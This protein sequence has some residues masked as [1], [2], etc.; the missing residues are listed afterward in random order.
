MLTM[1][2]LAGGD[3]NHD[4]LNVMLARVL[5]TLMPPRAQSYQHVKGVTMAV[6][7]RELYADGGI[8]RF[9]RGML[10]ALIMMPLSRFGDIFTNRLAREFQP[11]WLPPAIA[12][13]FA[14]SLAAGWRVLITPADTIKT[15]MQVHGANG[16]S[17][18]RGKVSR[19]GISALF[20]GALGASIA[21]WMGHYPWF[22]THNFLEGYCVRNMILD[23][24]LSSS[25]QN[26]TKK[27][28]RRALTGLMSSL[29]SD[30]CSNAV[31]VLKT[32]KQTSIEHIGY[33]EAAS[34]IIDRDGLMGLLF[35]GLSSKLAANALNAIIFTV[36]WKAISERLAKKKE[37]DVTTESKEH[38][39]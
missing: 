9:Y 7:I 6:A 8:G 1:S 28:V 27:N 11:R 37:E 22:V 14:S 33:L 5:L 38:A 15:M 2:H 30:V 10:P 18:L 4:V 34:G 36:V 23:A 26:S 17:I 29:V 13:M 20:E 32:Y 35:R 24:H 12:T 21:T 25:A 19:S 31:R 39:Q 3:I 16:L